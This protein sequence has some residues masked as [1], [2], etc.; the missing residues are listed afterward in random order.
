MKLLIPISFILLVVL[1]SCKKDEETQEPIR[2][3]TEQAAADK[4]VDGVFEMGG[5]VYAVCT[6]CHQV[7]PPADLPEDVS[8][9]EAAADTVRPSSYETLEEYMDDGSE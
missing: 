4:D 7:Y 1:A 3:V 5:T 8:P 6:A 2:D 9:E